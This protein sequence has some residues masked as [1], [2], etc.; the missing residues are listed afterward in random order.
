V[1]TGQLIDDGDTATLVFVR[2]LPH[3]AEHVWEAIS[4]PDG[5]AQWLLATDVE[6]DGRTGGTIAMKSG[7]PGYRSNGK[8]LAWEPPRLLEYEWNIAPTPPEMPDVSQ[9]R[10]ADGE[11]VLAR[12]ARVPRSPRSAARR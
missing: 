6:I 4:T 3:T 10:E 5:L 11:W 12:P 9:D 7:P 1:R 2:V 8:I